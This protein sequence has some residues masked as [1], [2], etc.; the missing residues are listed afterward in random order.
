MVSMMSFSCDK[1]SHVVH[2]GFGQGVPNNDGIY[3]PRQIRTSFRY[4]YYGWKSKYYNSGKLAL[5]FPKSTVQC[6]LYNCEQELARS[7]RNGCHSDTTV[8]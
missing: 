5:V 2:L 7:W 6:G 4:M 3:N 8:F 1:K